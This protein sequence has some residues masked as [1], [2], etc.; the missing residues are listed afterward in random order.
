MLNARIRKAWLRGAEVGLMGEPADLTYDVRHVGTDRA[1][2]VRWRSSWITRRC[3]GK[4]AVVI[5]GQGAIREADGEAVLAQA[6]R[7]A[8]L[9]AAKLLV[10]HT[11]AARVGAMD[12]GCTTEGGL[13]RRD[14]RGRGDL[15]PWRGRGRDRRRGLS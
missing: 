1:A 11:A 9:T 13:A 4:P 5:V 3:D 8:E 6:M 14:R 2:L 7:L 12:V 15:Q 10:L